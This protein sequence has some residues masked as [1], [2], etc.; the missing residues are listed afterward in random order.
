MS[1]KKYHSLSSLRIRKRRLKLHEKRICEFGGIPHY[2]TANLGY[3]NKWHP[4]SCNRP[5][6]QTCKFEKVMK[7]KHHKIIQDQFFYKKEIDEF[8]K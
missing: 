5:R 4:Y 3:W 1:M 2:M 8:L 7:I 6:C